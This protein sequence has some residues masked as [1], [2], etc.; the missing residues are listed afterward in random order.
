MTES[1]LEGIIEGIV[2]KNLDIIDSQKERAAGP[3]MGIVMKELRGR[4]SGK[5]INAI[6]LRNI[7]KRIG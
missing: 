5:T 7:R 1:E 3:L 6:L 2:E 4:A